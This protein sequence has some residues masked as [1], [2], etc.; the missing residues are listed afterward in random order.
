MPWKVQNDEKV[1]GPWLD[2]EPDTRKKAAVLERL[3]SIA[4]HAE[5]AG[6][7]LLQPAPLYEHP[8]KRYVDVPEAGVTIVVLMAAQYKAIRLLAI[9]PLEGST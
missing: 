6:S 4:E 2:I 3:A 5:D 1:L 9:E 7:I 8:L